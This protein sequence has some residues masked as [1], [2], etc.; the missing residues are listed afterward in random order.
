MGFYERPSNR[1]ALRGTILEKAGKII[2]VGAGT[3]YL[4]SRLVKVTREN[5]EIAAVDLSGQMLKNS[6][7]YLKQHDQ[8]TPRL[9][10]VKA[11]CRNLP[12]ADETFDLYVSSY[13]FDLLPEQEL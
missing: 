4:L 1:E 10:F 3:G 9:I 12:W 6:E 7:N 11:D 13:L 2:D 8:L 5:Q